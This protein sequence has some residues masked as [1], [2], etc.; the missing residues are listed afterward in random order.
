MNIVYLFFCGI[1]IYA[2]L[3]KFLENRNKRID[4]ESSGFTTKN[5]I[6]IKM[7]QYVEEIFSFDDEDNLIEINFDGYKIEKL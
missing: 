2:A 3:Q 5:G 1:I 4:I 7:E 6:K